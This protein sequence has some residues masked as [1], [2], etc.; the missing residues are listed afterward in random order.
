MS[1]RAAATGL[2]KK[3]KNEKRKSRR[4]G[5]SKKGFAEMRSKG[6]VEERLQVKSRRG[7]NSKK[8]FAEMRSKGGVEERLQVLKELV[9]GEGEMKDDMI[10]KETA[11]YILFLRAQVHILQR[12]VDFYASDDKDLVLL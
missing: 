10:F 1:S 2:K 12:L 3:K 11:D 5:N 8:G 4:G 9:N 6:G 7:R